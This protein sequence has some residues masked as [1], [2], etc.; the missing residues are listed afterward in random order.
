MKRFTSETVLI[1][2]ATGSLGTAMAHAF[3]YE[4]ANVVVAALR[5]DEGAQLA[6][7]L[8]GTA[9]SVNLDVT[10]EDLW[11][12]AVQAT[13][14]RLGPVDAG[15]VE[16]EPLEFN[17]EPRPEG[18]DRAEVTF[19]REGRFSGLALGVRLWVAEGDEPIDSLFQ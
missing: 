12:R 18:V 3:G 11:T 14:E 10:S 6:A 16:V 4:G 19:T 13:E 8:P 5:A 9:M 1:T 7:A 2:G 15:A 17:G